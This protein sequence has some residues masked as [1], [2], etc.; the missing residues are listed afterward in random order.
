MVKLHKIAGQIVK[1]LDA[2]EG[3]RPALDSEFILIVR[4]RSKKDIK[5]SEMGSILEELIT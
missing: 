4:A 2:F 3:S 1:F 5:I